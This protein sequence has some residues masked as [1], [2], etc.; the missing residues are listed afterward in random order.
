[1]CVEAGL[2][3]TYVY[4]DRHCTGAESL[5]SGEGGEIHRLLSSREMIAAP[6]RGSGS[7]ERHDMRE[8]KQVI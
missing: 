8:L 7:V 4:F 1:M 3:I 5:S 6:G 2:S